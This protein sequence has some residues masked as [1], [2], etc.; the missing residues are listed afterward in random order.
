VNFT[1][2]PLRQV[3]WPGI[4]DQ[5]LAVIT[6]ADVEIR[7]D[8]KGATQSTKTDRE[9]VYHFFFVRPGAYTLTVR[10]TGFREVKRTASQDDLIAGR[11]DWNPTG[12]D[13]VVSRFEND[14]GHTKLL[15]PI[16]S[17]FDIAAQQTWWQI[18]AAEIHTFN[19]SAAN[20]LLFAYGHIN[21]S[22][23][24]ANLAKGRQHFQ[25][26]CSLT[27]RNS[28]RTQAIASRLVTIWFNT[29]FRKIL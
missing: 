22:T 15:S 9:G 13:R 8:A 24:V 11:M 6:E 2:K 20:Q 27:R 19:A 4:T 23:G 21:F 5:S 7:N 3:Q 12:S 26:I 14:S 28:L 10:H 16:N 18:H 17:A 1:R 29:R 25:H